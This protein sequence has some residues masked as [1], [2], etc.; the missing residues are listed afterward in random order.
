MGCDEERRKGETTDRIGSERPPH[1]SHV[2]HGK[3]PAV[4]DCHQEDG[5]V[6]WWCLTFLRP[7]F[8]IYHRGCILPPMGVVS[9]VSLSLQS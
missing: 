2:S 9:T 7:H 4:P 8:L 1:V 5:V 6:T 3:Q